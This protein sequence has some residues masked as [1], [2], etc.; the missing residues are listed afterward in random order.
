MEVASFITSN[1]KT[2]IILENYLLT[3]DKLILKHKDEDTIYFVAKDT[4]R[5]EIYYHFDNNASY[6]LAFNFDSLV[7]DKISEYFKGREIFLIDFSFKRDVFFE[8]FINDFIHSLQI[9]EKNEMYCDILLD[10]P[11][12]GLFRL[13]EEGKFIQ[14]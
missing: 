5:D 13:N 3:Y 7:V 1:Q 6:E 10:H 14:Y 8:D 9:N 4:G 2:R 12:K 11:H